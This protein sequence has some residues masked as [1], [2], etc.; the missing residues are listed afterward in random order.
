MA[1]K[2]RLM[3][4]ELVQ[5]TMNWSIPDGD[6]AINQ[7][8]ML[9]T[10]CPAGAGTPIAFDNTNAAQQAHNLAQAW[11][12]QLRASQPSDVTLESVSWVWNESPTAPVLH[13]GVEVAAPMPYS[14]SSTHGPLN[15]G[16]T[17]AL[18]MQTGI[19]GRSNHGRIFLVCPSS[20]IPSAGDPNVL[21]PG[22]SAF[23]ATQLPLFLGQVN[24]NDCVLGVGDEYSLVV[25]SFIEHGA[26]RARA[27]YHRV[28]AM[29]LSDNYMDFQ[30]RRAPGH[31]RHH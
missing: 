24:N 27:S 4:E 16:L 7:L 13:E 1:D 22:S 29:N 23:F 25:A 5:L 15:N 6:V 14:G 18:R 30:R 2:R 3:P 28:T 26:F 17:V 19:G 12:D 31:A 20:G 8:Y 10:S 9:H 21:D 11:H